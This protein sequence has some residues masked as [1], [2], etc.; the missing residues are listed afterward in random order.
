MFIVQVFCDFYV[1]VCH[2]TMVKTITLLFNK[3]VNSKY[4]K[5]KRT[6]DYRKILTLKAKQQQQAHSSDTDSESPV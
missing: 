5:L 4:C 6:I 3:R 1:M 2:T